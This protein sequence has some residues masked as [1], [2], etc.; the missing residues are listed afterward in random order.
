MKRY[1]TN[2]LLSHRIYDGQMLRKTIGIHPQTLNR[3]IKDGLPALPG[4]LP[5]KVRGEDIRTYLETRRNERR[6]KLNPDQMYC[7][8][9]R[10]GRYALPGSLVPERTGKRMG[11]DTFQVI[12]H[13][14]C[15][16]CGGK[17]VRYSSERKENLR[18]EEQRF[19]R[20]NGIRDHSLYVDHGS[21][22]GI[23]ELASHKH[24]KERS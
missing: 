8:S 7:M 10:A 14:E 19:A 12:L 24:S 4:P 15:H 11:K 20:L 2:A 1:K 17:M 6:C 13:A 3:W 18:S 16:L 22:P 9:C 23:Q 21:L 5:Y